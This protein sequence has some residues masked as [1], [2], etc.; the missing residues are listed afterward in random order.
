MSC[1][2]LQCFDMH[3]I[4]NSNFASK[5][6]SFW[7]R[8]KTASVHGHKFATREAG[9]TGCDGLDGFLQSPPAAFVAGLSQPDAVRAT[10]VRGTA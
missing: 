1:I 2:Y 8:L 7:G 3:A 5:L 6:T 4:L 10:L 9:Q